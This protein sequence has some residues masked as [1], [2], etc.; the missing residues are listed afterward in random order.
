MSGPWKTK[1][2]IG[3]WSEDIGLA[4]PHRMRLV[5]TIE[6]RAGDRA[7]DPA[8][9]GS[10][11]TEHE[12]VSPGTLGLSV[13]HEV[14][15]L[16]RRRNSS[17]FIQG[18]G[19]G[20]PEEYIN[21]VQ[22]FDLDPKKAVRLQRVAERWHLSSMR[23][24]CAHMGETVPVGAAIVFP[25]LSGPLEL[26]QVKAYSPGRYAWMYEGVEI[27]HRDAPQKTCWECGHKTSKATYEKIYDGVD[28]YGANRGRTCTET[29]YRYGSAWLVEILPDD[30][31]RE[32]RDDF[33][34]PLPATVPA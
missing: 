5:A 20:L 22:V 10:R 4:S 8:D 7:G 30:L 24:A 34:V 19:A 33:G 2:G 14:C 17:L 25:T 1:I 9:R 23:A 3:E 32:L 29:G 6:L 26:F 13:T 27:E 21:R 11:T 28:H 16:S 12:P 18:C 31:L 15:D